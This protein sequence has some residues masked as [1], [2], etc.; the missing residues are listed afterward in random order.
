MLFGSVFV[1]GTE[2]ISVIWHTLVAPHANL[3]PKWS[4]TKEDM[5]GGTFALACRLFNASKT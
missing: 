3:E 4:N 1:F 2:V 5:G